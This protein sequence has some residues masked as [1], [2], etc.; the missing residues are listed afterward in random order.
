[1]YKSGEKTN[2]M[3][4]VGAL[5][6]ILFPGSIDDEIS[7]NKHNPKPQTQNVMYDE[8]DYAGSALENL[9]T[10][11]QPKKAQ[12]KEH[13][14]AYE[15]A[16]EVS[17]EGHL[18]LA[19]E[20]YRQAIPMLEKAIRKWQ[21]IPTAYLT[22]EAAENYGATISSLGQ[23]YVL[24]TLEAHFKENEPYSDSKKRAEKG[25]YYSE[26]AIEVFDAIQK[27]SQKDPSQIAYNYSNKAFDTIELANS[28]L[29]EP[30]KSKDKYEKMLDKRNETKEMY[31][32]K[33]FKENH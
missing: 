19:K 2:F 10:V 23:S 24:S 7:K 30:E 6:L 21:D 1:M 22:K 14:S 27:I 29:N 4:C 17:L 28:Y 3:G 26:R 15:K 5:A 9:T 11:I 33:L 32:I 18:M 13:I 20:Q 25:K 12:A 8:K 16:M 31:Y